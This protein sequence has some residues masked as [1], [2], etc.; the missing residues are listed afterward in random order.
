MISLM[1]LLAAALQNIPQV[2]S[3]ATTY[4]SDAISGSVVSIGGMVRCRKA[5]LPRSIPTTRAWVEGFWSGRNYGGA[6]TIGAKPGEDPLANTRKLCSKHP[7]WQL[8]DA[9][10]LAYAE[11]LPD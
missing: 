10:R 6:G 1:L 8:V 9:T 4:G 11:L 3:N 2:P 7:S 5:F